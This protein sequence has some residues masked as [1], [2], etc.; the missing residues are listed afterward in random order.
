[1]GAARER[2]TNESPF[3][4]CEHDE[5]AKVAT[6]QGAT[7]RAKGNHFILLRPMVIPLTFSHAV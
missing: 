1:L 7:V 3:F 5:L 6:M 4:E 2:V